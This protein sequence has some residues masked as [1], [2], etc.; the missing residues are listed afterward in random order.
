M[1]NKPIKIRKLALLSMA[2]IFWLSGMSLFAQNK[3]VNTAEPVKK[4]VKTAQPK[5]TL[6]NQQPKAVQIN[7]ATM[8]KVALEQKRKD[9]QAAEAKKQNLAK[10]QAKEPKKSNQIHSTSSKA[11]VNT[12]QNA[13]QKNDANVASIQKDWEVKKSKIIA[14]L[15]AKGASQYDIDKQIAALEKQLNITNNSNK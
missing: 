9:D 7:E 15:K 1:L 6:S 11:Q 13:T 3:Q 5:V 8:K 14:D 2:L 10:E 4:Q 12:N